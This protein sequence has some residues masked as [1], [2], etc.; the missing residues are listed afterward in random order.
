MEPPAPQETSVPAF[1]RAE[2]L[3]RSA[4]SRQSDPF[5]AAVALG[6]LG[7]LAKEAKSPLR[8]VSAADHNLGKAHYDIA[9]V[10][11]HI[12]QARGWQETDHHRS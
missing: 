5:S 4:T 10:G 6:Q 7:K 2:S 8:Q 11:G 3:D 1:A 12:P 9:P